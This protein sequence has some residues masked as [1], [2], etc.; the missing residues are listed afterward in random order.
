[1]TVA[2]QR[3]HIERFQEDGWCALEGFLDER[4]V[5][6]LS[7]EVERFQKQSLV[8]N[9]RT[10]G[11]GVT[12][13]SQ[14]A[15]LQLI[16]LFDK[17]TLLRTLP[18][19]PK[20]TEAVSCLI[21]DPYVLHLDQMFLKPPRIGA[22][23]SWHQDN[24]YFK[25]TDPLRGTAMWLAVH[26]AT[27]DNGTLRVI[28]GSHRESYPHERDPHSDHHICCR[29]PEEREVPVE[30]SAGGVVFFCYGI[31]HCTGD[32][33][34][35]RARA[36]LAFHFLHETCVADDLLAPDRDRRPWVTGPKSNGG[37][38]EY[39]VDVRGSFRAEVESTLAAVA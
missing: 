33:R 30:V 28:P 14:L 21:G 34:T 35:D 20:V 22:G 3:D 37:L 31:A 11:D 4:E 6:A 15:N 9:V 5:A 17:S 12:T 38:V 16:P 24:A 32:N 27:V 39:G 26:D 25:I 8:R 18:F 36:G 29:V 7:A 19:A 10:E 23:T 1:V 2:I 13:S